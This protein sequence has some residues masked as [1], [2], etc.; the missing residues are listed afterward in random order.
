MKTYYDRVKY[1]KTDHVLNLKLRL[2]NVLLYYENK[3]I[4]SQIPNCVSTLKSFRSNILS[5]HM[6][7][8]QKRSPQ[9]T[10]ALEIVHS[11]TYQWGHLLS[12]YEKF[13]EKLT[14]LTP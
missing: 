9:L 3:C 13:S 2:G 4:L 10:T 1:F 12:T 6:R 7:Q 5:K 11:M 14:F 8:K